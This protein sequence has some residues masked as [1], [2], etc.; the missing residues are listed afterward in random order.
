[1]F[2]EYRFIHE[3]DITC[4]ANEGL[5]KEHPS[6]RNRDSFSK[7]AI[8]IWLISKNEWYGWEN[9]TILR[10]YVLSVS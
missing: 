10:L 2:Q 7:E 9:M 3:H 6:A 4:V 8:Q 5:E 1:M